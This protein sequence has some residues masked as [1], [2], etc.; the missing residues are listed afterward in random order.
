[1][2]AIKQ[3]QD[4]K[5]PLALAGA[6]VQ[7][8]TFTEADIGADYVG[9]LNDPLL[10]RYS[11]QRFR[12]HTAESCRAYLASFAGTDN[13]FLSIRHEG[14]MIGTMTAYVSAV[15]GTA[16]MGL[17]IGAG[18]QGLGLGKDAWATLLAHLLGTGLRKVTGGTLS[19]NGAMLGVM[20]AAGMEP[21]GV[22]RAQELVDG[23]PQDI[24]YFATFAKPCSAS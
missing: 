24:L 2:E 21:D 18:R 17:L 10:M 12:R 3:N 5:A 13:L 16:D 11:N 7:L 1:M 4:R 23:V 14:R 6:R 22:R 8:A 20:R 19:C 9:W 15:H